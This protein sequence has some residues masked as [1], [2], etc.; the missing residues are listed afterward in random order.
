MLKRITR[1]SDVCGNHQGEIRKRIF[2][3]SRLRKSVKMLMLVLLMASCGGPK[4][5]EISVELVVSDLKKE[6]SGVVKRSEEDKTAILANIVILEKQRSDLTAQLITL[7]KVAEI[8]PPL[9]LSIPEREGQSCDFS[10]CEYCYTESFESI[11]VMSIKAR[12]KYY[13]LSSGKG[14]I[15]RSL[16][17]RTENRFEHITLKVMNHRLRGNTLSGTYLAA[18]DFAGNYPHF[19]LRWPLRLAGYYASGPIMAWTMELEA[20][21]REKLGELLAISIGLNGVIEILRTFNS[22]WFQQGSVSPDGRFAV[23]LSIGRK[24]QHDLDNILL[25]LTIAEVG[26]QRTYSHHLATFKRKEFGGAV[27][28]DIGMSEI[29]IVW[30]TSRRLAVKFSLREGIK[31]SVNYVVEPGKF[32]KIKVDYHKEEHLNVG[33]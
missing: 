22:S 12:G 27:P 14:V 10:K 17:N 24:H 11:Y 5:R 20:N 19:F 29:T 25:T 13:P 26:K 3:L 7:K 1:K 21:G 16:P 31:K 32:K 4:N 15:Q 8:Y 18:T 2:E 9:I 23:G 6:L 28:E 30:I 33:W